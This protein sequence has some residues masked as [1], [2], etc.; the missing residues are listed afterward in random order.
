MFQIRKKMHDL[1]NNAKKLYFIYQMSHLLL[2]KHGQIQIVTPLP[3]LSNKNI[4][5]YQCQ[6]SSL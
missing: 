1:I 2:E 4:S 6:L 3:P 5:P